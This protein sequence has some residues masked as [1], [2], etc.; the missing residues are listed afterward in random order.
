V[1]PE[2]RKAARGKRRP[3]A[4]RAPRAPSRKPAVDPL[5]N[6]LLEAAD[7]LARAE[8]YLTGAITSDSHGMWR[9]GAALADYRDAKGRG[10]LDGCYSELGV[11]L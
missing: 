10:G 1:N 5:S 4:K 9:L 8:E 6:G 7:Q 2:P 11:L 3:K